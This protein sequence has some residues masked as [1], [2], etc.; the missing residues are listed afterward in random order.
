MDAIEQG[1]LQALRED[2]LDRTT[3]LVYADWLDDRDDPRGVFLRE[4]AELVTLPAGS[5][6]ARELQARLGHIV[7]RF[8]GDWASGLSLL[9]Y[10]LFQ[11]PGGLAK[12]FMRVDRFVEWRQAAAIFA[13]LFTML[14]PDLTIE[15]RFR[16]PLDYTLFC[17]INEAGWSNDGAEADGLILFSIDTV[18]KLIGGWPGRR[19]K[20]QINSCDLWLT[21]GQRWSTPYEQHLCCDHLHH[22]FGSVYESSPWELGVEN[23]DLIAP[24]FLDYLRMI[25]S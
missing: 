2:P 24:S 21:I 15:D 10:E 4:E 22:A 20:R 23:M 25:R 13:K 19:E 16:V 6:R 3:R 5:A 1:F 8:D 14:F 12:R 11:M 18:L 17:S 9:G 7:M